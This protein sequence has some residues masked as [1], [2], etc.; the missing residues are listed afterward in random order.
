MA[1][2]ETP[3][4]L[5]INLFNQAPYAGADGQSLNPNHPLNTP[6]GTFSNT[7]SM[8]AN[9]FRKGETYGFSW[10]QDFLDYMYSDRDYHR[11]AYGRVSEVSSEGYFETNVPNLQQRLAQV[12][13]TQRTFRTKLAILR[14]RFSE[15]SNAEFYRRIGIWE[16]TWIHLM[17]TDNP[18]LTDSRMQTLLDMMRSGLGLSQQWHVRS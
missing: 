10:C 15:L 4:Y 18:N 6:T 3:D 11:A 9:T 8:P 16:H 13:L 14:A 7:V 1:K 5:K 2:R 17:F 12:P